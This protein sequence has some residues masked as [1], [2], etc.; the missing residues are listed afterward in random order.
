MQKITPAQMR[1]I[2][3]AARQNGMDDDLPHRH[4]AALLKKSSLAGADHP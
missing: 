1:K 2:H 3:M 4:M